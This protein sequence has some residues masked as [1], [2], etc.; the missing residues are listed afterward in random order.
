MMIFAN[1]NFIIAITPCLVLVQL[2]LLRLSSCG[3]EEIVAKENGIETMP[4]FVFP[5]LKN[6]TL[7]HLV[8]KNTYF[9]MDHQIYACPYGCLSETRSV[10]NPNKI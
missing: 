6:L 9:G 8:P 10:T 4:S 7:R 5:E 1:T 3:V 2:Q